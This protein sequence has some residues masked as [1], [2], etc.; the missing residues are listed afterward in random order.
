VRLRSADDLAWVVRH[1][2][3]P[4]PLWD[5]IVTYEFVDP[6]YQRMIDAIHQARHG[7][8]AHCGRW[9]RRST[10]PAGLRPSSS[11]RA[12]AA[13]LCADMRFLVL[14]DPGRGRPARWPGA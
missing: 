5:A 14:D 2:V 9:S 6:E 13:T 11:A 4:V 3:A 8:P 12:C 10:R 7:R 1:G